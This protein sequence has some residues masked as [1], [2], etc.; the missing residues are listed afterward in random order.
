VRSALVVGKYTNWLAIALILCSRV[1]GTVVRVQIT[2]STTPTLYWLDSE[3]HSVY[4]CADVVQGRRAEIFKFY[5]KR[6]VVQLKH[7][8]A[9]ELK[10]QGGEFVD[11][12]IDGTHLYA[13]DS[14]SKAVLELVQG[15][16]SDSWRPL[17][18]TL[19][20][21]Q[22]QAIAANGGYVYLFD[23]ATHLLSVIKSSQVV[24]KVSIGDVTLERMV[25]TSHEIVGL[26]INGKRIVRFVL[27]QTI[28]GPKQVVAIETT[29]IPEFKDP[30]DLTYKDSAF[31][32]LDRARQQLVIWSPQ[33]GDLGLA[34]YSNLAA[35]P[36]ALTS[37]SNRLVFADQATQSFKVAYNIEPLSIVFNGDRTPDALAFVYGTLLEQ[38]LLPQQSYVV[39][40]GDTLEQIGQETGIFPTGYSPAF[41]K[42]FCEL[43]HTSCQH[44]GI[45][46]VEGSTVKLPNLPLRNFIGKGSVKLAKA[47]DDLCATG[48][49][50]NGDTATHPNEVTA[51]NAQMTQSECELK[52]NEYNPTFATSKTG[53]ELH[54]PEHPTSAGETGIVVPEAM[55]RTNIIVSSDPTSL[56]KFAFGLK[57]KASLSTTD[58]N[59]G[60]KGETASDVA[61][62]STQASIPTIPPKYFSA[63]H[64]TASNA[65]P[66]I[67]VAIVDS[68]QAPINAGHTEFV[69]GAASRVSNCVP[70][71]ANA[72]TT[73]VVPASVDQAS[74]A[75]HKAQ[76]WDHGTLTAG[77]IAGNQ[78]GVDPSAKVIY[79]KLGDFEAC[80]KEQQARIF[81]L[82]LGEKTYLTRNK[83]EGGIANMLEEYRSV[84]TAERNY[85]T[86]FII[87]AGNDNH[88]VDSNSL[89]GTGGSSNVIVV[90]GAD[91]SVPPR[92]WAPV[93]GE[94]GSNT[95]FEF[96]QVMSPAEEL[97]SATLDGFYASASGTS[98]STAIVSGL[99]SELMAMNS[100]WLPYQ[101]KE[102]IVATSDIEPWASDSYATGGGIN[103]QRAIE[104]TSWDVAAFTDRQ[105]GKAVQC[106]GTLTPDAEN[107]S[108]TLMDPSNRKTPIQVSDVKR[109]H[110]DNSGQVTVMFEES[111]VNKRKSPVPGFS[112]EISRYPYPVPVSQLSGIELKWEPEAAGEC[113]GMS[114]LPLSQ[115]SDFIARMQQ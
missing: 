50:G 102:R 66:P 8:E 62:P 12:A 18:S 113:A 114:V 71:G 47:S 6:S 42:V 16:T 89:A 100:S 59:I 32:I 101:I 64:R 40:N 63:I 115:V 55:V 30:V 45:K 4:E 56:K 79:V 97:E 52:L 33:G 104:D 34:S 11:I 57:D 27:G 48:R 58:E 7:C 107:T 22:P 86:L 51:V 77:L 80:V 61:T 108:L 98:L 53:E 75:A 68:A 60:A 72:T 87:A 36:T 2:S 39:K 3:S 99:A 70:S 109:I 5:R 15:H 21:V 25:A 38:K 90:G 65:I 111:I 74:G 43:N 26:D 96:V 78:I 105:T 106:R 76:E 44:G 10:L 23:A 37:E 24:Q 14:V 110:Q 103:E 13:I 93:P 91:S 17:V 46:L 67:T 95:S 88:S 84:I 35:H 29:P 81:N 31:Y 92:L 69:N 73:T 54:M 94:M 49:S 82:S 112:F 19:V 20:T 1:S 41:V 83:D 28:A 85:Q 9:K